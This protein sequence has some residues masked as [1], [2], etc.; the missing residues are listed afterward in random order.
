[1][2]G[3]MG[4]LNL[5]TPYFSDEDKA[6]EYLEKIRWA[7]GVECPHCKTV[8]G[9]YPLIAKSTSNHPVRKGVWKC[10]HCRKQ[11]SVTV[12]TIFEKS[13]IPLNKWLASVYLLCSSKKGM[14]ANQLHRMLNITYK[15]AWFMAHRIR[16]AMTKMP[17]LKKFKG[18]VEIDET[19]I[20]GKGHGKRGRGSI[21]KT[22]VVAL[23]ERNGNVISKH[24]DRVTAKNLKTVLKENVDKTATL[25]T[26]DFPSY[27]YLDKDFPK[28]KIINHSKK[29]MFME[30][31]IL[32]L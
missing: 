17:L 29:N 22:P 2:E 24:I 4:I 12:G 20:G 26:D 7:N 3:K 1:M 18:T 21:S 16:Y 5:H 19:Y 23:V 27:R 11:F 6:R 14:S 25:M 32:T 28:H 10:N 9:H 31:F 15:S 8:D 30:I 13:H